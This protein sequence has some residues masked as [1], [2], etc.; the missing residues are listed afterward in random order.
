M[1]ATLTSQHMVINQLHQ[2]AHRFGQ[3]A[4]SAM[5]QADIAME[6]MR[7]QVDRAHTGVPCLQGCR[8]RNQGYADAVGDQFDDRIQFIELADFAQRDM[9]LA[10]EP[11]DL[12][13]TKRRS[14]VTNEWMSRN[15]LG[16]VIPGMSAGTIRR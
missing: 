12:T 3:A 8:F 2:R 14:I 11:V 1:G 15:Q 5:Y 10:Q 9:G 16:P 7:F 6:R 4:A 13:A